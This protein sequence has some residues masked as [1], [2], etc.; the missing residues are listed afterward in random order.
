MEKT[1]KNTE[2]DFEK[3]GKTILKEN[4]RF[5][6]KYIGGMSIL[7]LIIRTGVLAGMLVVLSTRFERIVICL[8]AL[9]ICHQLFEATMSDFE[10]FK[11]YTPTSMAY[12]SYASVLVPEW[13]A[14]VALLYAIFVG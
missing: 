6:K 8:L 11:E 2:D 13:V 4:P 3:E 10:K 7:M 5:A 1:I 14:I 9:I 12:M